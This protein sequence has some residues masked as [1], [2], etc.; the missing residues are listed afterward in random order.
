M[1]FI[2][3]ERAFDLAQAVVNA[4]SADAIDEFEIETG[5]TKETK[6]G[7]VF[8]YNSKRFIHDKDSMYQLAGNGPIF[9]SS[10][11]IVRK[12]SSA[13]DWQTQI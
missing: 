10:T 7:W 9:V 5:K 8:F 2:D 13:A 6:N 3:K 1:N 4:L 12:L 11:G